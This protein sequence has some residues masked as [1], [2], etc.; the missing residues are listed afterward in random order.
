MVVPEHALTGWDAIDD[1]IVARWDI[2]KSTCQNYHK[3]MRTQALS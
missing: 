2:P 3:E 1:Y